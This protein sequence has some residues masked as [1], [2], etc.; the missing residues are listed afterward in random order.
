MIDQRTYNRLHPNSA[1]FAFS[2]NPILQYDEYPSEIELDAD[3]PDLDYM[4]CPH[5]VQGFF[6]KEKHWGIVN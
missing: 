3:L 6:L 5:I 2:I 4:L 1:T